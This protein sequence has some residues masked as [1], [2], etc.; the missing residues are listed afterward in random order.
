MNMMQEIERLMNSVGGSFNYRVVNLGGKKLYL[1]GIKTIVFL[2]EQEMQFQLK[3]ELLIIS[4]KELKIA[5]LD[6][7]TSIIAGEISSVVV[8]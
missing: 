1:E 2:S 5:Y 6:K 3:S 8:K 4:G 7:S